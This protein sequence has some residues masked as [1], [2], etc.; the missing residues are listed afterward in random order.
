MRF[1]IRTLAL[2]A[3]SLLC[4]TVV[5]FFIIGFTP[6]D[7]AEIHNLAP[8][9]A[10]KLHLD[11]PLP[12]RFILWLGDALR[13]DFGPS[14]VDGTPVS[15]LLVRYAPPTLMLTF[16][17]LL[18]SFFIALPMGVMLGLY[19]NSRWGKLGG[20]TV[21]TLSSV[22]V[23]V[24]GYVALAI[25][26]G[27]FEFYVTAPPEGPFRFWPWAGYYLLPLAVLA[28]GNGTM[29]QFVRFIAMEVQTLNGAY[30]VQAARARGASL[31]RHF[32]KSMVLPMFSIV[33][34]N[35]AVLLGGVVVVERIFNFHGLGWLSWEATLK[36]DFYV[37]MG[38][39][40][41]MALAVRTFMLANDF[42]AYWLDPR[43]RN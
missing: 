10:Q 22:P 24:L 38:I 26:F 29:G 41:F 3:A 31:T 1:A 8:A 42:L 6:G 9:T 32:F 28:I 16:G 36:R 43:R 39:T 7:I 34:A 11:K 5:V 13:F 4:V 23:F 15:D 35:L 14:M 2:F 30:F 17:S 19:P 33:V 27:V 37:V 20:L 21:Y 12:L 18:L 25:V 40:V